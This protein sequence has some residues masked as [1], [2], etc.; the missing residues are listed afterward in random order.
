MAS[1]YER[2]NT[3]YLRYKDGRGKWRSVASTARTK[4]EAR[5]LAGELE[6]KAER[7]RLGLEEL[8]PE[9]GGGTVA[10]LM[11]WWLERYVRRR[12]SYER[13][14]CVVQS[15][16]APSELGGLRL[17]D[18]T[19][20]KIEA[21]LQ[22][23]AETVG[24]NTLNHYR[25][26]LSAAFN[27]ARLNGRWFGV[28]P[29]LAVPRRTVPKRLPDFLRVDE[30]P[31][32]LAVLSA[33]HRPL[34]ATAVYTGLRK[35]E[36]LGLRKSDIDFKAALIRV[37]RS[38]DQDTTK[39]SRAEAIPLAAELR[40]YL[41][42]AIKASPSELVFP[43]PGGRMMTKNSPLEEVLRR[44]LGRA[45]IVTGY[46]HVCRKKGCGHKELVGD[47]AERR[48]PVHNHRLWPKAKVR[49]IRF[50]DLRHTTA[51][52]LMAAGANP[53]AVQR[54]LRH[55]DPRITTEVYGHLAPDYLQAEVNRLSFKVP[56]S[57]SLG[58]AGD[59]S[60]LV[61]SL[62][63]ASSEGVAGGDERDPDLQ[64]F[65]LLPIVGH[66]GLEPSASGLRVRCSTN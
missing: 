17:M 43:G 51:S 21:F 46:E 15:V 5:R 32:V 40:P 48:C 61:T 54:I 10:G 6:R 14:Q 22:E 12:P 41:E 4:T 47:A 55:S 35:G 53:A 66:E 52:L 64:G 28:N 56:S 50:H 29:V 1:V 36:L 49:P 19:P 7:Q 39:G 16:I 3:W 20:A 42:E 31:R 58:I 63:Q 8:P 18:A 26:Y 27:K 44:A 11:Q 34:F 45:G 65:P 9:D 37:C 24:P 2:N 30:V 59:R 13:T 33:H 62:L 25:A 38:Y 57:D 23:R 60:E